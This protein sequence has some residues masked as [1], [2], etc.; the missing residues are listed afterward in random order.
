[1]KGGEK[2][3]RSAI[4]ST[5][6]LRVAPFLPPHSSLSSEKEAESD[7]LLQYLCARCYFI[8]KQNTARK[9][10]RKNE[11]LVRPQFLYISPSTTTPVHELFFSSDICI[12]PV[13]PDHT[14]G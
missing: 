9:K 7:V 11:L 5:S 6:F 8:M 13:S 1:V 2:M 4:F 14:H 12:S 3:A 10:Y